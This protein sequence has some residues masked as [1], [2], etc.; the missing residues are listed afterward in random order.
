ML[1][2]WGELGLKI[3]EGKAVFEPTFLDKAEFE[4]GKINF[5]WCGTKILYDSEKAES[6]ELTFKDGKKASF[7]GNTLPA[8]ESKKLF[9]RSG[10]ISQII[11]G[12]KK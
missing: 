1:T 4:D 11:V 5:T 12:L 8:A 3:K 2:R 9:A 6:I 10:E 7:E